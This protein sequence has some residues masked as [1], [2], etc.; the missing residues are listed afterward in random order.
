MIHCAECAAGLGDFRLEPSPLLHWVW[1][2]SRD[3]RTRVAFCTTCKA[4]DDTIKKL[5]LGALQSWGLKPNPEMRW[6]DEISLLEYCKLMNG[7]ECWDCKK[8]L[9]DDPAR[10]RWKL[11]HKK[12]RGIAAN[13]YKAG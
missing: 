4:S 11:Y 10:D 12:C 13:R 8:P 6:G 2:E 5:S 9:D 3:W 1:L 7:E